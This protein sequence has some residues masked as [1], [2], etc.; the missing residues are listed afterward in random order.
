L[1]GRCW[2]HWLLLLLLLLLLPL[3]LSIGRRLGRGG[4]P[5]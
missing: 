2:L 1:L 4:S 3:L 5:P